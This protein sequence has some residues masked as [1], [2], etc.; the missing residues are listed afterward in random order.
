MGIMVLGENRNVSREPFS[1]EKIRLINT[2]TN[3]TASALQRA[4]LHEQ[5]E[6]N[7]VQTVLALANTMDARDTYTSGHSQNLA[8][9]AIATGMKLNIDNET[10]QSMRWGALLHDI[11]KIGVP[12]EILRKPGPL[13]KKEWE[14][15]KKH[16]LIGANI[17][18][19]VK[20]LAN[21]APIIRSH[22]EWYDGNGYPF[23]LKGD[24]IPLSARILTVVDS[25]S[26]M[27]DNRIYRKGRSV[28]EA[29]I[30][31]KRCSGKQFDPAVVDAFLESLGQFNF[32]H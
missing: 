26:A 14:E 10:L 18:Q 17:V 19:P 24:Q 22:H 16:P 28:D 25:F 8:D 2:I 15:M 13:T 4:Q 32:N 21:V 30:E 5:M 20:K 1:N 3:Q 12:D 23:G 6:D 11:G 29:I 31:L 9:L 27:I 7:F